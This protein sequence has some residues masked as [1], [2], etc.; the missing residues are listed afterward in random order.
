MYFELR[1]IGSRLLGIG[2]TGGASYP[3]HEL[4]AL[5][6]E[7]YIRRVI[8]LSDTRRDAAWQAVHRKESKPCKKSSRVC[9][10]TTSP[11]KQ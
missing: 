11:K 10:L 3:L 2:G 1:G 9:G 7:E 6:L 5:P 4:T 8:S